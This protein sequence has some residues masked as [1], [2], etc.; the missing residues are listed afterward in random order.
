MC[1]SGMLYSG[2]QHLLGTSI[3]MHW[4]QHGFVTRNGRW[5]GG[6]CYRCTVLDGEWGVD[7]KSVGLLACHIQVL[8]FSSFGP[9]LTRKK[10]LM[11]NIDTIHSYHYTSST[12]VHILELFIN[13]IPINDSLCCRNIDLSLWTILEGLVWLSI[14]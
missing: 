6:W 7:G 14:T 8:H 5:G 2:T 13:H 12:L 11:L 1:W 3:A 9:W 10:T 4:E